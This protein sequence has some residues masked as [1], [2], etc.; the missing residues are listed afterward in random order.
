M[1]E[2]IVGRSAE[3]SDVES[4]A[5]EGD[6]KAKL[7]LLLVEGTGDIVQDQVE[8][9]VKGIQWRTQFMGKH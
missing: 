6:R 4:P 9:A 1:V 8:V 2:E 5:G 7:A 3:V